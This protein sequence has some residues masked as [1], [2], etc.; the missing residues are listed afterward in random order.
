MIA[1][2]VLDILASHA[3]ERPNKTY[4]SWVEAD[5][6]ISTS[7]TYGQLHAK[8]AAWA[9]ELGK[10]IQW[11]EPVALV[12]PFGIDFFVAF[13]AVQRAGGIPVPV[14]PPRPTDL[15]KDLGAFN[16]LIDAS[17][18]KLCLTTKGYYHA[19]LVGSGLR[20]VKGLFVSRAAAAAAQWPAGLAWLTVESLPATTA[21][22]P[23][24]D[25]VCGDDLA[26]LQ[27]TSGST[28]VPKGVEIS[29]TN[30][31]T[32]LAMI[33]DYSGMHEG[34]IG[35]GWL[36]HFHDFSLIGSWFSILSQGASAFFFSPLDY[37]ADPNTWVNVLSRYRGTHAVVP[38]FALDLT[39]RKYAGQDLD[40]SALESI[41]VGAEPI[42][43]KSMQR[44][45]AVFQPLGLRS[46]VYRPGYGMAEATLLVAG[47]KGGS[48]ETLTDPASGNVF[49]GEPADGV[50]VRLVE[51]ATGR[52]VTDAAGQEGEIWVASPSVA[53]GYR[54]RDQDTAV[55]FGHRVAGFDSLRFLRT[56]DLGMFR[57][58]AGATNPQLIVTGRMKDVLVI[59]GRNVYP[60]DIEESVWN[61]QPDVF[62]AGSAALFQTDDADDQTT[63][64]VL[65]AEL[66]AGAIKN[67]ASA[68][69]DGRG[70]GHEPSTTLFDKVAALVL[71]AHRLFL[72]DIVLVHPGQ[73]PR[74]TSG[75]IRRKEAAKLLVEGKLRVVDAVYDVQAQWQQRLRALL[76]QSDDA[77]DFGCDSLSAMRIAA[78]LSKEYGVRISPADVLTAPTVH[79]LT[80][81]VARAKA[82]ALED[83][84]AEPAASL[85]GPPLS[86]YSVTPQQARIYL[87]SLQSD[88]HSLQYHIAFDLVMSPLE[89]ERAIDLPRLQ[90]AIRDV[91]G[92][93]DSLRCT[94]DMT[95]DGDVVASVRE[96]CPDQCIVVAPAVESQSEFRESDF[97]QQWS[98]TA[99]DQ[100]ETPFECVVCPLADSVAIAF[101]VHHAVFDGGSAPLL[102]QQISDCYRDGEAQA[103]PQ[104]SR[105]AQEQTQV[106]DEVDAASMWRLDAEPVCANECANDEVC[107]NDDAGADGH[108]VQVI[109]VEAAQKI[110]ELAAE[111]Q[112]TP[113]VYLLSVFAATLS[114]SAGCH[115]A[116]VASPVTLRTD[117]RLASLVGF[118]VNTMVVRASGSVDDLSAQVA[119]YLAQ[120]NFDFE[121]VMAQLPDARL[122]YWF[123]LHG[124]V[125]EVGQ[126]AQRLHSMMP[127]DCGAAKF[128]LGLEVYVQPDDSMVCCWDWQGGSSR[129]TQSSVC[130]M[131]HDFA[132]AASGG[133][134]GGGD[135]GSDEVLLQDLAFSGASPDS[136]ALEDMGSGARY[137]YTQLYETCSRLARRIRAH[138]GV[139]DQDGVFYIGIALERGPHLVM[140]ILAILLAGGAYVPLD[141]GN[142]AQRQ[143]FILSRVGAK[144]LLVDD[145][146]AGGLDGVAE[147]ILNV[148]ELVD[149]LDGLAP[150]P[151]RR[152][153]ASTPCY[154]LFTSG[155]TGVPKG[156]L[157]HHS[158]IVHS[159]RAHRDAIQPP[160]GQALRTLQF[161]RYTFDHSVLEMFMTFLQGGT[162]VTCS[163]DDLLSDLPGVVG[164]S[165]ASMLVLTPTVASVLRE[166]AQLPRLRKLILS[167][168]VT[169]PY[170]R[171]RWLS[172]GASHTE[173]Y[174]LYGTT[175]GGIHQFACRMTAE[176]PVS[177]VGKPLAGMQ[178]AILDDEGK[179]VAQ[180]TKG[181]VWV[182]GPTLGAGY[183]GD[184]VQ[185]RKF[186][187]PLGVDGAMHHKTGDLGYLDDAGNLQLM[188]RS[189]NQVKVR[190]QRVEIEEI[191]E[192][193]RASASARKNA[194]DTVAV[195][196]TAVG[197]GEK[198]LAAYVEA[199]NADVG[200]EI[201]ADIAA[202]LP[203]Y[204]V[205]ATI[206]VEE[207]L[208]R[209]SSGKLDRR[210]LSERA[211]P[212]PTDAT[213]PTAATTPADATTAVLLSTLKNVTGRVFQPDVSLSKQGLTSLTAMRVLGVLRSHHG[214]QAKVSDLVGND[215][216]ATVASRLRVR[217]TL[218]TAAAQPSK[219]L[220]QCRP[221]P[222]QAHE[223]FELTLL[224]ESYLIGR[225]AGVE[226]SVPSQT[227]I[228][229]V[230]KP[231]VQPETVS[232]A[233]DTLIRRHPALRLVFDIEQWQQRVL[234]LEDVCVDDVF[235][236]TDLCAGGPDDDTDTEAYLQA[237]RAERDE[238]HFDP[239]TWPLFDVRMARLPDR[240]QRLWITLDL[241]IIDAR[242]VQTL[243]GELE[244]LLNSGDEQTLQLQRYHGPAFK[245]YVSWHQNGKFDADKYAESKT[246]WQ[247]RSLAPAPSLPRRVVASNE[248]VTVQH[249]CHSVDAPTWQRINS[250]AESHALLPS[251]VLMTTLTD[252]VRLWSEEPSFTINT[253][254]FNRQFVHKDIDSLV[255]DLTEGVLFESQDGAGPAS[256]LDRCRLAQSQ[257]L[258]DVSHAQYNSVQVL[259]DINT[260]APG[261]MMP[262]VFTCV[263][264][265]GARTADSQVVAISERKTQ[266]SQV[267]L[268]FQVFPSSDSSGGIELHLDFMNVFEADVA[269][270]V[271]AAWHR[272]VQATATRE[273]SRVEA[274]AHAHTREL[275][276]RRE[277]NATQSTHLYRAHL[278]IDAD[279]DC[280]EVILTDG[281]VRHA[282]S[283][284]QSIAV[285]SAADG[286]LTYG[287]LYEMSMAVATHIRGLLHSHCLSRPASVV[288]L[289]SKSAMQIAAIA[290]VLLSGN[291]YIPV[292]ADAPPSRVQ[293]IAE[294]SGAAILITSDASPDWA[295]AAF[296]VVFELRNDAIEDLK[297]ASRD[298]AARHEMSKAS[299]VAYTIFTS[300]ST[301]RPKGV[302]VSHRAAVNTLASVVQRMGIPRGGRCLGISRASFDLSVWDIF[303][304]FFLGG[305]LVLPDPRRGNDP[306]HWLELCSRSGI[307]VWNTVPMLLQML[308]EHA[309]RAQLQRFLA[310]IDV[311]LLSG[312]RIPPSLA[313][314][315]LAARPDTPLWSLG[316][317]TEA[318]VWSIAHRIRGEDTRAA[319]IPY[320]TPL[321]NQQM[322]VFARAQGVPAY[323]PAPTL[324]AG[325]L[326][327]A[328]AG[329]AQGYT[330]AE[331]T[332]R[333][334]VRD[335][336]TGE[337][338]YRTGD[339]A[340]YLP[341]GS[342]EFIGRSDNQIKIR[343]FRIELD[344]IAAVAAKATDGDVA[345]F[346]VDAH[347][348]N[349][350]GFIVPAEAPK[351]AM[352]L[353][354]V[355]LLE[356]DEE[357]KTHQLELLER[358]TARAERACGADGVAV[359]VSPDHERQCT[360]R[361]SH[362]EFAPRVEAGM[363]GDV[364]RSLATLLHT[365][366]AAGTTS[367][368]SVDDALLA[369]LGALCPVR[370]SN[371]R[372]K[373]RYP[374]AGATYSVGCWVGMRGQTWRLDALQRTLTPVEAPRLA[375][376]TLLFS[377]DLERIAPLYGDRSGQF[378][379]E[380]AGY[381]LGALQQELAQHGAAVAL[382]SL[383]AVEGT[384]GVS[385]ASARVQSTPATAP[386]RV[387]AAALVKTTHTAQWFNLV[388]EPESCRAPASA[389]SSLYFGVNAPLLHGATTYLVLRGDSPT[390]VAMR[391]QEIME[392]SHR[393]G[394]GF[395]H[396]PHVDEKTAAAAADILAAGSHT[397]FLAGGRLP[398]AGSS[399]PALSTL[400]QLNSRLAQKLPSYML[401]SSLIEV[402]AL[403][404][405]NNGKVDRK[406]LLAMA[407]ER[408]STPASSPSADG[409]DPA[410]DAERFV[411]RMWSTSLDVDVA[412]IKR[413][414]TFAQIGGHSLHAIR[415]QKRLQAVLR[416]D[417]PLRVLM[418][419]PELRH[420]AAGL[421]A[422]VDSFP[423]HDG[424][425]EGEGEDER[426]QSALPADA[427]APF[428]LT[429]IQEAY[430]FGRDPNV[431]L[432]GVSTHAY[433]E[434]DMQEGGPLSIPGLSQLID[435]LIARHDALRIVFQ[436]DEE[437]GVLQQRVLPLSEASHYEVQVVDWPL[438]DVRVTKTAKKTVLHVS[439]DALIVDFYS[440]TI[441]VR[442]AMSLVAVAGASTTHTQLPSLRTSF[443]DVVV[444]DHA[445]A[446]DREWSRAAAYWHAR[447]AD[448]PLSIDLPLAKRPEQVATPVF[449]R[450]EA[451]LTAQQ[452]ASLQKRAEAVNLMPAAVIAYAFAQ[453]LAAYAGSEHFAINLTVF[454][455]PFGFP[456]V[457]EVVGDFTSSILL[458]HKAGVQELNDQLLDDLNN[459]RFSG[460]DMIRHLRSVRRRTEKVA[461]PVVMTSVLNDVG[462][463][464]SLS[465]L[466]QLFGDL[467]Y[468]IS[469]TPQVWIDFQ[470]L[471]GSSGE[472]VLRW[473]HVAELF[474]AGLVASMHAMFT[475]FV[476]GM[477]DGSVD[478]SE[479]PR[480]PVRELDARSDANDTRA[481]ERTPSLLCEGFLDSLA[482]TP[483]HTAVIDGDVRVSYRELAE[484]A[485]V[486]RSRLRAAGAVAGDVVAVCLRKGWRQVAAT[487]AVLLNSCAYV[488]IEVDQPL[489][490]VRLILSESHS[491]AVISE[492]AL[493]GAAW[494]PVHAAEDVGPG[495]LS[496]LSDQLPHCD[497]TAY[498]I[499][500]SGSTGVPKG[501]VI[502][503]AA[504]MNTIN[505]VIARWNLGASDVVFGISK[506]NFD[507]SVFDL[508]A[509]LTVGATLVLPQ[510]SNDPAEWA[511]LV[512]QHRVT[513][514][515]SVPM[516]V[517]MLIEVGCSS[518]DQL[519]SLRLVLM[520]GDWIPMPL[521][522]Q[523]YA[524]RERQDIELVSLGGATEAAIWSVLHVITHADLGP[525]AHSI[526]YGRPMANQQMHVFK[527]SR[528]GDTC[529]E[530]PAPTWAVGRLFIAGK[531][532]AQGYT[533]AAKTRAAFVTHPVT[534]ERLYDTGDNA[535]YLP[536]GELEF[537]GRRDTQVKVRGHRIE[538]GEILHHI[539]GVVG[540]E[541]LVDVVNGNLVAFVVGD[542]EGACTRT[543]L[544]ACNAHLAQN[545]PSYMHLSSVVLVG[546]LPLSA[547]GKVDRKELHRVAA[548]CAQDT[549]GGARAAPSTPVE[550]ALA[551]IWSEVLGVAPATLSLASSFFELGGDS[552]SAL[553]MQAKIRQALGADVS[554]QVIFTAADLGT[555]A[556]GIT[557]S[558][559]AA[560]GTAIV[561][562]DAR[563][564]EPFALTPIQSAYLIG[565]SGQMDLGGVSAHSYLEFELSTDLFDG[566]MVNTAVQHLI[567]QHAALRLVFDSETHT[568]KVL[569]TVPDY[570]IRVMDLAEETC[571]ETADLSLE[572]VRQDMEG[573]VLDSTQWPLFDLALTVL[574]GGRKQ[575]LHVS[576]D[577]LIMDLASSFILAEDFLRTLRTVQAGGALDATPPA[578]TF[579]Q[580]VTAPGREARAEDQAYWLDRGADFPLGPQLT[581]RPPT[582][583]T[584]TSTTPEFQRLEVKIARADFERLQTKVAHLNLHMGSVLA[585]AFTETLA[586]FSADSRFAVNLTLFSRPADLAGAERV[587]GD[588]TSCLLLEHEEGGP[589][590]T[591]A[592][593]SVRATQRQLL[594]DL[595]HSTFS[596]VD[597]IRHLRSQRGPDVIFPVVMTL[598]LNTAHVDDEVNALFSQPRYAISQTPQVQLDF[599]CVR[600]VDGSLSLRF[601]YMEDAYDAAYIADLHATL[602][603]TVQGMCDADD[604]Y[605]QRP[606]NPVVPSVV[607]A[608]RC[609]F[610]DTGVDLAGSDELLHAGFFRHVQQTPDAIAVVDAAGQATYKEMAG[611]VAALQSA[612][613]ECKGRRVGVILP[614][615]RTQVAAVLAVLA[616]GASY[617]PIDHQ[618]PP[619][620]VATILQEGECAAVISLRD[621]AECEVPIV[622][623]D[624][625]A[626][627]GSL[628][629]PAPVCVDAS[630]EA[631]VIFTS[632]STG[633]PKG[634]KISHAG[635]MNTLTDLV[636]R[637]SLS[638]QDRFLGLAQLGFDLSVFDIF[639]AFTVGGQLVLPADSTKPDPAAWL[640]L[641]SKHH[642]TV[643]NSVPM[644]AQ[645]L[646][647]LRGDHARA[648]SSLRVMFLSGDRFPVDLA[649]RLQEV[650]PATMRLCSGGGA[651]EASI[652][653]VLYDVADAHSLQSTLVPYGRPM[654]NQSLHVRG[655][656]GL[657]VPTMVPGKLY[658][659]GAGV[660]L[661]YTD[662][663]KTAAA[664][665]GGLYNTGDLVRFLPC[666]N[667]EFIGRQDFQVKVR[668]HRIEL[669]EVSHR[670]SGVPGVDACAVEVFNNQL[671]G[672]VVPH[673]S[674]PA[675]T[676]YDERHELLTDDFGRLAHKATYAVEE[677][678]LTERLGLG[679]EERA[680]VRVPLSRDAEDL[681]RARKS[682]YAFG[683]EAPSPSDVLASLTQ[684]APASPSV[685][686]DSA[687]LL[688]LLSPALA[689][690]KI[691]EDG[692]VGSGYKYRYP[693]AGATYSVGLL[694]RCHSVS[695]IDDGLWA[696]DARQRALVKMSDAEPSPSGPR[697][698]CFFWSHLPAIAPLYG[699]ATQEMLDCEVGYLLGALR[700]GAA[701][702][703]MSVE[704]DG[705]CRDD[706][707]SAVVTGEHGNVCLGRAHFAASPVARGSQISLQTPHGNF[708]LV[709]G[710]FEP[711]PACAW[712]WE[713]QAVAFHHNAT[714]LEAATAI[715]T[716]TAE[717]SREAASVAQHMMD[718][719]A[720]RGLGW[721]QVPWIDDA[722][723]A[724]F[725]RAYQREQSPQIILVGGTT[726]TGRPE[727]SALSRTNAEL[728]R[729]LPSYMQ[730]SSLVP[731]FSGGLPL[732]RNGKVDRN[733]LRV[734]F[735]KHVATSRS[736]EP[737]RPLTEMEE[738]IAE[739]WASI[740]ASVDP[741]SIQP[742]TSFFELG[743]NSLSAI[744]LQNWITSRF[745]VD[746]DLQTLFTHGRLSDL[747]TLVAA[748]GGRVDS[749]GEAAADAQLALPAET[750]RYE[751][752]A[753]TAIQEAYLV[754]RTDLFALGNISTHTHM[755]FEAPPSL[756]AEKLAAAMQAV[757]ERHDALRL[758]FDIE[759]MTQRVIPLQDLPAW[760]PAV[761][762]VRGEDDGVKEAALAQVRGEMSHQVLPHYAWPLFDVRLTRV[763]EEHSV[764]HV[765]LDMLIMD[766]F[767][768][769]ILAKDLLTAD[770][771]T[772]DALT[773][774]ALAPSHPLPAT[775]FTFRQFV[776]LEQRRR[777]EA[778]YQRH[779]QYW[780]DRTRGFPTGGPALPL[781]KAMSEITTPRFAKLEEWLD[782]D[783][784]ARLER[785]A[786]ANGVTVTS[787]IAAAFGNVLARYSDGDGHFAINMTVFS[788]PPYAGIDEVVGDFTTSILLEYNA[789]AGA[790]LPGFAARARAVGG[791]LLGDVGHAAYSGV[792]FLRHIKARTGADASY[793]VV[794]TSV[795]SDVGASHSLAAASKM[796]GKLRYSVSQTPQV[797]ID[798]QCVRVDGQLS[799]RWDYLEE[800]FHPGFVPAAHREFVAALRALAATEATAW[801]A[802]EAPQVLP[803]PHVDVP[804]PR[805]LHAG[806]FK[807]LQSRPDSPC[808]TS[809][810][811]G[812]L[813]YAQVGNAVA[814]T[815]Q[816]LRVEGVRR[817]SRVGVMMAKGWE[818]VAA[819][820]AILAVGGVYVPID[821]S[822]PTARVESIF[823]Q[824]G[825]QAV[826][827]AKDT[828]ATLSQGPAVVTCGDT[829]PLP[830]PSLV[831][832][833][834]AAPT[835]EAY[836][837]F[838]SGSTGTPKGVVMQHG[839]AMN[840]INDLVD[841]WHCTPND[842]FFGLAS[843]SFDLS[844]F[845]IFAATTV[846]GH[847]VLPPEGRTQVAEWI[848]LVHRHKVTVW[849]SVPMHMQMILA[850]ADDEAHDLLSSLRVCILSG[851][852]VPVS[853]AATL[854]QRLPSLQ[855]YSGGGATEGGIWSI[856]YP[857][858]ALDTASAA[859][860]PYG[861]AMRNQQMMV[862][863]P[864]LQSCP[865]HVIG[866]IHIGGD[867]L[868]QGYTDANLTKRAFLT[869]PTGA[870]IYK[871]GDLGRLL[872]SGDIQFL[873]RRDNQVQIAGY[874]VEVGEVEYQLSRLPHVKESAVIAESIGNT[875]KLVGFVRLQSSA[876]VTLSPAHISSLL[877]Q[878]LPR[879]MVPSLLHLVARPLPLS[880]NGKIDRKALVQCAQDAAPSYPSSSASSSTS[881][882][883]DA[884]SDTDSVFSADDDD[885][886]FYDAEGG[887]EVQTA[888]LDP[889]ET[890]VRATWA[891]VLKR[892]PASIGL[893]DDFFAIGGD[894]LTAVRVFTSIKRQFKGVKVD[895]AVVL[896]SPT[897][898]KTAEMLRSQGFKA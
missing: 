696:L 407:A 861:K 57:V 255:G 736:A 633:K 451:L 739:S 189:D 140:S 446:D 671:V 799:V 439:V 175:E 368:G 401:L 874:R 742:A 99:L 333:A 629:A 470:A 150:L 59:H 48:V 638:N 391:S 115:D 320:G 818:Q 135:D 555:L 381:M 332:S 14:S 635:A 487:L 720:K 130:K 85:M 415:L 774:D 775:T 801:H 252:A 537:C 230:L 300:G 166:P 259:R 602:A 187:S 383:P 615:G 24:L 823:Q 73:M 427:H 882:D 127:L 614:K 571:Q 171:E 527:A 677:D 56:G 887:E 2:T 205:P 734:I 113:Y 70:H 262:V 877:A 160:Q 380:E 275:E 592:I 824:A 810:H 280:D 267:T 479:R 435:A 210:A 687:T 153:A 562:Q 893:L 623:C 315:L 855:A 260:T 872:P 308:V 36:P 806:F 460:V 599:Q 358:D 445:A 18:A 63:R 106:V 45:D 612:L 788:R 721:T 313:A 179:R 593:D 674:M 730:L 403:P 467:K 116:F 141:L 211:G 408:A 129:W 875:V 88:Y 371:G 91:V 26:F 579:K 532:L 619:A 586:R 803:R 807:N 307:S 8:T 180:G 6:R 833:P 688:G 241:L 353:R 131:A 518:E 432:G 396:V 703:G 317:A 449:D 208:P 744:K 577:M 751:P 892:D 853:L 128:P 506:L 503:H 755:E 564:H 684:A 750:D 13:L 850:A 657:P 455:R 508:F 76:G 134:G 644:M 513:V 126:R 489:Q 92:A 254:L 310:G 386:A 199:G 509:T 1:A 646:V 857:L 606:L 65:C 716:I 441:L 632:G 17:G 83:G 200:E 568:Q 647:E 749:V 481:G 625:L 464:S 587:V 424:E 354:D 132:H 122:P 847:L 793:P 312:D 459:S 154:V 897:V 501:V 184:D 547:N 663:V 347:E 298:S 804:G 167:G 108:H 761:L 394:F 766:F 553:K 53:R 94:M 101:K 473:D 457:E 30:L 792:D 28:G 842:V 430:F 488:P 338:L 863:D 839:A 197:E 227:M 286:I 375:D 890:A 29:H 34:S 781:A 784:F 630:A 482:R 192:A 417:V 735:E 228:E 805:L 826:V 458:E 342:L 745:A 578:L 384:D 724:A 529:F 443:R 463:A 69:R 209:T 802:A 718:A 360:Q 163:Q 370:T 760:T 124:F 522:R 109:S 264:A 719:G 218:T 355:R 770:A 272:A 753:L 157:L 536:S 289:L 47:S 653:S 418:G 428:P 405:T 569:E 678:I 46:H 670:L 483:D 832:T 52:D 165:H 144:A 738:L 158:N 656:D 204:M 843:L 538:L 558:T 550:V 754:G 845:D 819:C 379:Q 588:F 835:D 120:P 55:S 364:A 21:H 605:W 585:T 285:E 756:T 9:H 246:Y 397:I 351:R 626:A 572:S 22:T 335:P 618:A 429:P 413:D 596:G 265:A 414:T 870:R 201:R 178:V 374:S 434:F 628:E 595:E 813:T 661:G 10:K 442:D 627:G 268:D 702:A 554:I 42:R 494:V 768:S 867:S 174:N 748:R 816:Q 302:V 601:D 611:I 589:V 852:T 485:V 399:A 743:G 498:I 484:H 570:A 817:G 786:A 689:A 762:D 894:S 67:F 292:D 257:L 849:N 346:A 492:D 119:R 162:V 279:D 121:S 797:S 185:T 573:Q 783:E 860:V 549:E 176:Q 733:Q 846:G 269:E 828:E 93:N 505:D 238:T 86:T 880:A 616:S 16:K 288:V 830:G 138:A 820:L 834:T 261:T 148:R 594:K 862:L 548:A 876:P 563:P 336:S 258:E 672:F 896:D 410:T 248:S 330:N 419:Q 525:D 350:V 236:Y 281:L 879:Y 878:K 367:E 631:Y 468:S 382:Q 728:A 318:A 666:G 75:K 77:E 237:L 864:R 540:R 263:L 794:M 235:Q 575:I 737:A 149:G 544:Q 23:G 707:V 655:P 437:T 293:A 339:L 791:Q 477:C 551:A 222:A 270:Q 620:R 359:P 202:V 637:W 181:H 193:I 450:V 19:T 81:L 50:T 12:F 747:A 795:L 533:N 851:D 348:G 27:Y 510:S 361:R 495:D 640:D 658:I 582:A 884:G 667:L 388:S 898:Q 345:G 32:N 566:E 349:L 693:S 515:N 465:S 493:E 137:T 5:G 328:G 7:I 277:A 584:S 456:D 105:F 15:D 68:S 118:L 225:R 191:E 825:I 511:Q 253:T 859:F 54:E 229:V 889:L 704:F 425:G 840:T 758:V 152:V 764:L 98:R 123:N 223:P 662:A 848:E 474:P 283:S 683:T 406:A 526:P 885:A 649:R 337:R 650:C 266:T 306:E 829:S 613:P 170:L 636:A 102:A 700:Q 773:A 357:R 461:F 323:T 240:Q 125:G 888:T 114:R 727:S 844:V 598:I 561:A 363:A 452:F 207:R 356:A 560:C 244:A 321:A 366:T 837:I 440:S 453:T 221:N 251:A 546:E 610:N 87:H 325:D 767:S 895:V 600:A 96:G 881:D 186:F 25:R 469:Q 868:A 78:G 491:T 729:W 256:F 183:L 385:V 519:A 858:S 226:L 854:A 462:S 344:E 404:L 641:V 648:L 194:V 717:S 502:S 520:S 110:R 778:S 769:A 831:P 697:V 329:L 476:T 765:S 891:S 552:L 62:K 486:L 680:L 421:A 771:L 393:V 373:Y 49:C 392:A 524:L 376:G 701:Q 377:C 287:Q 173:L 534:G 422:L 711:I 478:L 789:G 759:S 213:M 133:G 161:S 865:T 273:W 710:G 516:I 274:L 142:P 500:T 873:G 580:I 869:T 334:F 827:V 576:L 682:H 234:R 714:L 643:W 732:S 82:R 378:A 790:P 565:R 557:P 37:V 304:T 214:I 231:A 247:K 416:R 43:R 294:E 574:P 182:Q 60:Q 11:Q 779:A 112:C 664:F 776:E 583:A 72:D 685:P 151:K 146:T 798:F 111:A 369:A 531:G 528:Q 624:G 811:A 103:Q 431:E 659:G 499:F 746:L 107:A 322:H 309:S 542:D 389:P 651:T 699:S 177:F 136:I 203:A 33:A 752:F 676:A 409:E 731:L 301:G 466:D 438:F 535:R 198:G 316:G 679:G 642:V 698:Q 713:Q 634:V 871:T 97:L 290:G 276:A 523:L 856:T 343:G 812:T 402:P 71:S 411:A 639:A 772:A 390:Q 681:L 708:D 603:S 89:G 20:A 38:N 448:F 233:L 725:G 604:L 722:W 514:W 621:V 695:G 40:L 41:I 780:Q 311:V 652:W 723:K 372:F 471:R 808:V 239:A 426:R 400:A 504:A 590:A 232:R 104:F 74:T 168:E 305:T 581:A 61:E 669:E 324:V 763:S 216:V 398:R 340:R 567:R 454:Q 436:T 686:L 814:H 66:R 215:S 841:G 212:T 295:H 809:D 521:A 284:P 319:S 423:T 545:V 365:R 757:I 444:A 660:A 472:L 622:C 507:L 497:D 219:S 433:H 654:A 147:R 35:V 694:V 726:A 299:D 420:V 447:A 706:A 815:A 866:E 362:Y 777:S 51:P 838:T 172:G 395:T 90:Q 800:L 249:L 591:P 100:S 31:V 821:P 314:E 712:S 206:A 282:E 387:A 4:A 740:L 883:S 741:A 331:Q 822:W 709:H 169:P 530:E 95:M 243:F 190:G 155:S 159:V 156:C 80:E 597:F 496:T 836:I 278:G 782:A 607:A 675:V 291:V 188:G 608:E 117:T 512:A 886:V 296:K 475:A 690:P 617:V 303:G 220:T 84:A 412:T 787:A 196:L 79:G 543:L 326:Y 250:L 673:D 541:C 645:M 44:F 715:V 691:N 224:Q 217:K 785:H 145:A 796:L 39:A 139:A 556:A 517:R 480:L 3:A 609:G 692:T 64:V 539:G 297:R 705:Q 271:F 559:D 242:S 665:E 490:R 352:P 341:D 164:K 327:I 143:R 245:D 195:V 58:P 668:G